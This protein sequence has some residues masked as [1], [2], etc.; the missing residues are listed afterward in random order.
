M[1]PMHMN[2]PSQTSPNL[3]AYRRRKTTALAAI[4]LTMAGIGLLGT[5]FLLFPLIFGAKTSTVPYSV[6]L[7]N[8]SLS[9]FSKLGLMGLGI[10]LIRR[11]AHVRA[12]A[13]VGLALSLIHSAYF[14]A[15]VWPAMQHP[16]HPTL[17]RGFYAGAWIT[18]GL[19]LVLYAGIFIYLDQ[20]GSR[21]EFRRVDA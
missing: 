17:G 10:F 3:L 4:V 1:K 11:H 9:M 20:T 5:S 19:A 13:A 6:L 7:V 21:R 15:A 2:I 8:G 12:A 18:A 16:A 14:F